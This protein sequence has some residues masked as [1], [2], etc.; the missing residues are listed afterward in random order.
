MAISLEELKEA[1][2]LNSK[3][4][5]VLRDK[6]KLRPWE[7][8]DDQDVST[9][10]IGAVEAVKK[11]K[12]IAKR[13]EQMVR[14][15]NNYSIEQTPSVFTAHSEEKLRDRLLAR[16]SEGNNHSD[17]TSFEEEIPV[18]EITPSKPPGLWGLIRHIFS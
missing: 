4:I 10:T 1:K 15:L 17:E 12:E 2:P 3:P 18:K 7:S 14:D 16:L 9:R 13:N 5:P 8:K 11:A 6:E